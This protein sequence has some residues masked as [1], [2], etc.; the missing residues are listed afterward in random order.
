[1]VRGLEVIILC[2]WLERMASLL[3]SLI[4]LQ[5]KTRCNLL[6]EVAANKGEFKPEF[7]SNNYLITKTGI[8]SI[9]IHLKNLL[10]YNDMTLLR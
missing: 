10:P 8:K 7:P 1:M 3:S 4:Q 6:P 5:R 2:D 9:K